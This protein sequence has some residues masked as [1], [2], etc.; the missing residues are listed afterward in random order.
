M[1]CCCLWDVSAPT[2]RDDL[3]SLG[4]TLLSLVRPLPWATPTLGHNDTMTINAS[5]T[6]MV[7]RRADC[8][9]YRLCDG[10]PGKN[11]TVTSEVFVSKLILVV[12]CICD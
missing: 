1:L 3:E 10:L 11:K 4:Y 8:S 2:R 5:V 12:L 9:M 6:F 7:L